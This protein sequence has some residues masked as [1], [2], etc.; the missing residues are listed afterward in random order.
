VGAYNMPEFGKSRDLG[1]KKT[2]QPQYKYDF[3]K[4]QLGIQPF[5]DFE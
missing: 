1:K 3:F 5:A 2:R 4:L